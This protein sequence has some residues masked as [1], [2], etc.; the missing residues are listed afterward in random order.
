MECVDSSIVCNLIEWTKGTMSTTIAIESKYFKDEHRT[1]NWIEAIYIT[2]MR[3]VNWENKW[4]L[5]TYK[6]SYELTQFHDISLFHDIYYSHIHT[7]P[8][9]HKIKS[10]TIVNKEWNWNEENKNGEKGTK[11]RST[12]KRNFDASNRESIE[13]IHKKIKF[14][15]EINE[16]FK[17]DSF[18]HNNKNNLK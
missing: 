10:S 9:K 8:H 12:K 13:T 15:E 2:K 3:N 4:T 16:I 6:T 18:V 1:E 5:D 7:Q 14:I 17:K 11:S